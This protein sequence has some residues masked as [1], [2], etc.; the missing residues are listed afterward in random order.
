MAES[1]ER[2]RVFVCECVAVAYR[3]CVCVCYKFHWKYMHARR[4]WT[5]RFGW[6][7]SRQAGSKTDRQTDRH[8]YQKHFK[9][10]AI[11]IVRNV[12]FILHGIRIRV[13]VIWC[14]CNCGGI[15]TSPDMCRCVRFSSFRAKTPKT[16][17]IFWFPH[18]KILVRECVDLCACVSLNVQ[19]LQYY[20]CVLQ[21]KSLKAH[22][23]CINY[24]K[25]LKISRNANVVHRRR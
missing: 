23:R 16:N 14:S 12:L 10:G 9:I 2:E 25:L 21:W 22:I 4:I 17:P 11:P 1:T 20:G 6:M 15:V 5:E 19:I 7:A 18:P 8:S 24:P 13:D 3:V